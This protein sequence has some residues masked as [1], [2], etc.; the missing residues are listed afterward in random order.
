MDDDFNPEGLG[1]F[2]FPPSRA[3]GSGG[4][5]AC[6]R[7]KDKAT[8]H[9]KEVSSR[10]PQTGAQPGVLNANS[11]ACVPGDKFTDEELDA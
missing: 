3:A 8:Q 1:G 4:M 9:K 10:F 11:R 2:L 7:S 6:G 5:A